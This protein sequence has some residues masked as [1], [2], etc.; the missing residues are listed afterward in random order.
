MAKFLLY[1][2]SSTMPGWVEDLKVLIIEDDR[3][4]VRDISL[5]L[6]IRHPD[7]SIFEADRGLQGMG[8]VE[9][10][11]P[12]LLMVDDS[13]PDIDTLELIGKIRDFSNI[14]LIILSAT[15]DDI[16]TARCLEAGADEY[17]PK[18][19]SPIELLARV[20]ALLRRTKGLFAQQECRCCSG[21][22]LSINYNTHEVFVSGRSVK[23]TPTEFRLLTEL[24]KNEGKVLS[25]N[26]LLEKT[27]GS[28]YVD[29]LS[30]L[31]VYV[32]RLRKKLEPD[33]QEPQMLLTDRGIGYR[34]TKTG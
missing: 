7:V 25:H 13:L 26:F 6:K 27:W 8:M 31:K 22:V 19:F 5:C 21:K 4:V 28:E 1:F 29:D 3:R 12:D 23:L 2:S 33:N 17:I 15:A 9:T 32:Y 20:K 34:F 10:E 18:P 30:S 14:P 16:E 11:S 24:V